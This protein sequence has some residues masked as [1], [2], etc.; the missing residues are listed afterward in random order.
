MQIEKNV[1]LPPSKGRNPSKWAVLAELEI[2]DSVLVEGELDSI[3]GSTYARA[4]RLDRKFT[5]RKIAPRQAR[6]WRIA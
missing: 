1:P 6:V 4:A 3:R 2:G 5:V